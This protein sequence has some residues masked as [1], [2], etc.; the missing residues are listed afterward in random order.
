M[1]DTFAE[2]GDRGFRAPRAM[3][4]WRCR[5]ACDSKPAYGFPE[6]MSEASEFDSV[7]LSQQRE[8]GGAFV[9]E[10]DSLESVVAAVAGSDHEPGG[11]GP[12]DEPDDGVVPH[13]Q[14]VG[15]LAHRGRRADAG[16]ADDQQEL[17]LAGGQ[18][19]LAGGLL[20]EMQEGAQGPPELGHRLV[21]GL[22]HRRT[23]GSKDATSSIR[24]GPQICHAGLPI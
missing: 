5:L 7:L 19:S 1:S 10:R 23:G 14:P 12:I 13:L 21:V 16:P 2:R 24:C 11:L 3:G 18:A 15:E 8:L 20:R 4:P 9:G 6:L 22:V 17:V